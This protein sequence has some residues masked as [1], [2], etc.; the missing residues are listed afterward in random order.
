M[1]TMEN[2]PERLDLIRRMND[3]LIEDCP[4]VLNFHKGFFVISP[5]WSP[6]THTNTLLEGGSNT[7]RWMPR[8]GSKNAASGT[9]AAL[10]HRSA[11]CSVLAAG[12]SP[13]VQPAPQSL[14]K[15]PC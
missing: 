11:D 2:S 5:P 4:M 6:L 8:C 12:A 10:A 3:I 9:S 1:S 14:I 15:R 13:C 7:C